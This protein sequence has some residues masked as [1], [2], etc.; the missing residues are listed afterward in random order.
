MSDPDYFTLPELN[1]LPNMAE[2]KYTDQRKLAAAAYITGIIERTCRTSFIP[3]TFTET[4]DGGARQIILSKAY[5]RSVTSATENGV[6]VTDV[7]RTTAAGILT[8]YQ[9]ADSYA[10]QLWA[11]GV[12]NVSVTYVAG[13]SDACPLDLKEVALQATRWRLMSTN[14]NSD[15]NARQTSI[16]NEQGV[17]QFTTAGKDRPTGYPD[18]DAVIIGWRDAVAPLGIA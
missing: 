3:R 12:N 2:A 9:A 1:A 16:S 10:P 8:R 5:V 13:Y 17:V 6:P 7:L 4:H 14:S 18:I 11:T 15:M